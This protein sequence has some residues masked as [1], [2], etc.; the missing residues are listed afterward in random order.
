MKLIK[1]ILKYAN[2]MGKKLSKGSKRREVFNAIFI[3]LPCGF[4][5][6]MPE[7]V[8]SPV[9][10]FFESWGFDIHSHPETLPDYLD[11]AIYLFSSL[12]IWFLILI[13]YLAICGWILDKLRQTFY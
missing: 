7:V 11:G 8:M 1:S 10:Q 3:G 6:G 5:I 4:V 12:M 9:D 13:L 2:I